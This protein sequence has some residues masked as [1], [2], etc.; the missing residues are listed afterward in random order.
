MRKKGVEKEKKNGERERKIN[1]EVDEFE[2]D[3]GNRE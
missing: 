3:G 1:L 2:R